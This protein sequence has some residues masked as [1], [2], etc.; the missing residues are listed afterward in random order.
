MSIHV[1]KESPNKI[2]QID[3]IY[4]KCHKSRFRGPVKYSTLSPVTSLIIC[5]N[6]TNHNRLT[7]S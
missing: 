5:S 1:L 2:S 4:E 6:N 3:L 7:I